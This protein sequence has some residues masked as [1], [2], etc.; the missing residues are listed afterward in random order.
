M[1]DK[2]Y[3]VT[4]YLVG[5]LAIMLCLGA[6]MAA[7]YGLFCLGVNITVVAFATAATIIGSLAIVVYVDY[8]IEVYHWHRCN[9]TK[10]K[11]P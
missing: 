6:G 5:I 3:S 9:G 1:S 11:R 4:Y 10:E 7:G 2:Y 8:R